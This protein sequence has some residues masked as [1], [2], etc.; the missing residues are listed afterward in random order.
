MRFAL[1]YFTNKSPLLSQDEMMDELRRDLEDRKE[2]GLTEREA[3][4]MGE[5]QVWIIL[6]M[7]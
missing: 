2:R 7:S 5:K 6:K 4:K 1:K 3:H